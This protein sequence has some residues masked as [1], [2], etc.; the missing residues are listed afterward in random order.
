MKGLF[1]HVL[2]RGLSKFLSY[3]RPVEISSKLNDIT[4]F[5]GQGEVNE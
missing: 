1:V 4:R 3:K 2:E 5:I